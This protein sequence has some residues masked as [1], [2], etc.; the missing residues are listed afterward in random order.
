MFSRT[1]ASSVGFR[2]PSST[3]F[4]LSGLGIPLFCKSDTNYVTETLKK[5]IPMS[6]NPKIVESRG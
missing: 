4:V 2:D 5:S 3:I 1:F 6:Q